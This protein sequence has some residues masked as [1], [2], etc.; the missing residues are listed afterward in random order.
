MQLKKTTLN[1][2]MAAVLGVSCMAATE[3]AVADSIDL[4]FSGAFTLLTPA[5]AAAVANTDAGG[6]PF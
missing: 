4:T 6:A 3:L 1:T 5:G 2:A